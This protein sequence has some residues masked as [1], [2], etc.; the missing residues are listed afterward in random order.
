[1]GLTEH[2]SL[3]GIGWDIP[4]VE[5]SHQTL[6]YNISPTNPIKTQQQQWEEVEKR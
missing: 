3:Q 4:R 2:L 1:M 5:I 6:G